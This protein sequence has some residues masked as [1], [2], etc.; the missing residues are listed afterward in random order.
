MLPG[1]IYVLFL[2]L[3]VGYGIPLLKDRRYHTHLATATSLRRLTGSLHSN[4]ECPPQYPDWENQ[5]PQLTL[6]LTR[7]SQTNMDPKQIYTTDV[8]P[9]TTIYLC[10]HSSPIQLRSQYQPM[11]A[12]TK[13]LQHTLGLPW[14]PSGIKN[15]HR[16]TPRLLSIFPNRS[17]VTT[18]CL[19]LPL[20][21]PEILSAEARSF[22]P[23][24]MTP[25]GPSEILDLGGPLKWSSKA[26][27]SCIPE[28][29]FACLFMV[30]WIAHHFI[31][32]NCHKVLLT[33]PC[34]YSD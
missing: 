17:P 8:G 26:L 7:I 28:I 19:Q 2:D 22:E 29:M 31:I 10:R 5:R 23:G 33:F 25:L 32:K 12:P 4:K 13:Y 34:S 27:L 16:Q 21:L 20:R 11:W 6:I 24:A 1:D 14:Y 3:Y 9:A 15:L 30:V 18:N